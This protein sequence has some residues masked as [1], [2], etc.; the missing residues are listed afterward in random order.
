ME[1]SNNEIETVKHNLTSM[2]LCLKKHNFIDFRSLILVGSATLKEHEQILEELC[3]SSVIKGDV[4]P[5]YNRK[6]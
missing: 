2:F 5:H 1:L 6:F 4:F 3:C